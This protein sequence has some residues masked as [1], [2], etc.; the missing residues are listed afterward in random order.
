MSTTTS[1]LNL[2]LPGSGDFVD[3]TVLDADFTALDAVAGA[4]VA[5]ASTRPSTPFQGQTLYETDTKNFLIHNGTAPASAGWEYKSFAAFVCTSSTRPASPFVGQR[6]WQTDTGDEYLWSG[7]AW[8]WVAGTPQKW[9]VKSVTG[10]LSSIANSTDTAYQFTTT[11]SSTGVTVG[12]GSTGTTIGTSGT[13]I[14]L[15][16]AG[17]YECKITMRWTAAVGNF[18]AAIRRYNS[19]NTEQ[20]RWSEGGTTSTGNPVN[21]V[22]AE[23]QC[24][25]GDYLQAWVWQ[26]SG[27]GVTLASDNGG[28]RFAGHFVEP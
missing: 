23:F 2:T 28:C 18:Y 22:S 19:S 10:T 21:A 12:G 25:A 16:K 9:I 1:R 20:E 26:N 15:A 13:K 27:S 3:V 17:L 7:S 14:T 4:T 11:E 6:I 8:L 24:S 5:T